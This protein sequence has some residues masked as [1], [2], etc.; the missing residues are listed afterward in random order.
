[1]VA[2]LDN[3]RE[4]FNDLLVACTAYS[5]FF[6]VWSPAEPYVPVTE[7]SPPEDLPWANIHV[8][9]NNLHGNNFLFKNPHHV[10][11]CEH[12]TELCSDTDH[13]PPI[14][15][16]NSW[17]WGAPA[18]FFFTPKVLDMTQLF[19]LIFFRNG[20]TVEIWWDHELCEL[21]SSCGEEI[22][23][24]R[25]LYWTQFCLYYQPGT[26]WVALLW[27]LQINS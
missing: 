27:N 15:P 1:M 10:Q 24:F 17:I 21:L 20:G 7:D 18:I 6:R 14:I 4:C 8:K 23:R 22:P 9:S 13:P 11:F 26:A 5:S 19:Y 3:R 16:A 2:Y 12:I 25:V